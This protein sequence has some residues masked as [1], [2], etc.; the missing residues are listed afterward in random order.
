MDEAQGNQENNKP[1]RDE[2]GRL[3]PG[4]CGNPDKI[5]NGRKHAWAD[6]R[7]ELLSASKI[8]LSLTSTDKD[9]NDRTRI[10][11]LKCD[12]EKTFRHAVL[13][14]QIQ[15]ALTGDNDAIRDLMDREEG[16]PV[17]AI[18]HGGQQDNPIE[19]DMPIS[20]LSPDQVSA[21]REAHRKVNEERCKQAQQE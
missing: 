15:N 9:G 6:I 20:G 18:N 5:N 7:T 14:R 13:V 16:K 1:L 17:Q 3:L 10:F 2:R 19:I 4:Q 12:E 21:I 11:D 8:K